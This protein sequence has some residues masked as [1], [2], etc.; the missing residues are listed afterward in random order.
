MFIR[1]LELEVS[2]EVHLGPLL[3]QVSRNKTV[4]MHALSLC[5]LAFLSLNACL[6]HVRKVLELEF[7][8]L[9]KRTIFKRAGQLSFLRFG[10]FPDVL[11]DK[12]RVEP[13]ALIFGL[14]MC[15]FKQVLI[16]VEPFLVLHAKPPLFSVGEAFL[17]PP[18]RQLIVVFPRR[19][20]ELVSSQAL[21]FGSSLRVYLAL[22]DCIERLSIPD[23][24][25]CLLLGHGQVRNE[26]D[27]ALG[28][29]FV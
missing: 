7:F 28:V 4:H 12:P 1:S 10:L 6:G 24:Q 14:N 11:A 26:A 13:L 17:R 19:H 18:P 20:R 27:F 22:V 2:L 5:L 16:L 25:Q 21:H 8:L 23:I 3:E 15:R 29:K 9:H